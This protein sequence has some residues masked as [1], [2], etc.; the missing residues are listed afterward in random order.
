MSLLSLLNEAPPHQVLADLQRC[1]G[2]TRWAQAMLAA[3]PFASVGQL[4]DRADAEW[5]ALAEP[6]WL[7]AFSHH[8]RI[9]EGGI[10]ALRQKFASTA[11]WASSEQA[12]VTA[13]TD[14]TLHALAA[15]NHAYADKFGFIF[16]VCATG[17]SAADMLA[18]LQARFP[19]D[20]PTELKNAAVE[21]SKIT[22][23]RLKK[24]VAG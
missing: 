5:F 12:G 19:N 8:P 2:S 10:E 1:C 21:Q 23:L 6:D 3:R 14:A 20:R 4:L 9:G 17:K 15:S 24:L 16:I 11:A 18:L 7:E 13:A 22:A